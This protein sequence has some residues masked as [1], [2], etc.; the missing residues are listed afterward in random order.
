MNQSDNKVCP[1][2]GLEMTSVF[3]HKRIRYVC[4]KCDDDPMKSPKVMTILNTVRPPE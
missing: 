4:E 2:C 1:N 3:E